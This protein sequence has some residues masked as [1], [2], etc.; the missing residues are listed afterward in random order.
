MKCAVKEHAHKYFVPMQVNI[1]QVV[2][3]DFQ[4]NDKEGFGKRKKSIFNITE[5]YLH[6]TKY[7]A[8]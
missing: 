8:V 5:T 7:S 3:C 6:L 2:G 1:V 4:V